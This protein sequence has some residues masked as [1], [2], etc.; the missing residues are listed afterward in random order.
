MKQFKQLGMTLLELTVVL[1]VLIALAGLTVPYIGGTNRKA[2]CD[3][4]D[5]SMANIKRAIMDRYFLDTLGHFPVSNGNTDFSL[6]YLFASG[7][8]PAFDPDSQVGW[9]GPYLMNG[10]TLE[11]DS[12]LDTNLTSAAGTYVHRAFVTRWG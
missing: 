7:G 10:A 6:H 12:A 2:L 9:R 5:V 4:T 8:W 11:S 3:A 1:L